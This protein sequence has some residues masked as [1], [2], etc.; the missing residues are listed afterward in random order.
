M[1]RLLK[2]GELAPKTG[3]YTPV[4]PSGEKVGPTVHVPSGHH[5]PPTPKPNHKQEYRP[6]KSK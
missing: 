3:P 4:N 1:A 6:G 5:L 2:P